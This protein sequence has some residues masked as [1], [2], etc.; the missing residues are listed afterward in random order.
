MLLT[1]DRRFY[2]S[3]FLLA[4]PIVL[5]NLAVFST[6]LA[7]NVMVGALGDTAV[8]GVYMGNQVQVLLQVITVG[9]EGAVLVPAAQQWGSGN[10]QSVRRLCSVGVRTSL[11]LGIVVMLA[12]ACFSLPIVSLFV[13]DT[14]VRAVGT[15]YLGTVCFSFPFFCVTQALVASMRSV[16]APRVGLYVS[17]GSFVCKVALNYVLIYGA[18]GLPP[19]GAQGAAIATVITRIL[20]AAV[21]CILVLI[22]D[23]RLGLRLRDLWRVSPEARATFTHFAR[24]TVTGQLVWAV[25]LFAGTALFGSFERAAVAALSVTNTM[26]S[27]CYIGANGIASAVAVL[28]AKTVGAGEGE[29]MREYARTVQA[30]ALALGLVTSIAV[31]LSTPFFLSLYAISVQA[32][33]EARRMLTVLAVSVIG[34]CYQSACLMGVVKGSGDAA[35]VC[36]VDAFFVFLVVLPAACLARSMGSAAWVVYACLKSDQVLKC[37]VAAVRLGHVRF[38]R[39]RVGA[40]RAVK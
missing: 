10:T 12:C 36:R 4:M 20:E 9:I 23:R 19:L 27:L 5:Q 28:T 2:R 15:G 8:S 16:E 26:N 37:A 32:T 14:D 29:R 35:F 22:F 17:L 18:A 11:M 25:N 21:I 13:S 24:S 31:L 33:A 1:R 38:D 39:L 34:T 6:T 40:A 3:L 7:D 30:I